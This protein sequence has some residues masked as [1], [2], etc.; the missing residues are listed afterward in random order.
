MIDDYF[1]ANVYPKSAEVSVCFPAIIPTFFELPYYN[2]NLKE[3]NKLKVQFR[4]IMYHLNYFQLKRTLYLR[5][6]CVPVKHNIG[7]DVIIVKVQNFFPIYLPLSSTFSTGSSVPFY[8]TPVSLAGQLQVGWKIINSK[9]YG[10]HR[11][12]HNTNMLSALKRD[13]AESPLYHA[14]GKLFHN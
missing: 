10:G 2:P 11:S 8:L 14:Q 4:G 6:N 7:I 3:S 5:K 12:Q 1:T 9:Q 13:T